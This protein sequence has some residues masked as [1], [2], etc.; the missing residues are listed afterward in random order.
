[1]TKK[2]QNNL[3][4]F[5][6]NKMDKYGG[7]YGGGGM[8]SVGGASGVRMNIASACLVFLCGMVSVSTAPLSANVNSL[9]RV[10]ESTGRRQQKV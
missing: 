10:D 4:K 8:S 7:K 1:M 6:S 3:Q 2:L 9:T 5:G